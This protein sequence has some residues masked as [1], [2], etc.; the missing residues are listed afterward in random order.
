MNTLTRT[1]LLC[2]LVLAA[3]TG[4]VYA[5]NPLL[6]EFENAFVELSAFVRQSV[7]EISARGAEPTEE[8]RGRLDD[9]FRRL[10]PDR[11]RNEEHPRIMPRPASTGSGFIYDELGHIVTNNHVVT[12]AA[13]VTVELWD[14]TKRDA[15]VVGVD[16]S[17]DIAVIKIDPSGLE[18]KPVGLGSSENLKVGQFAIA[19]GSPRGQTGSL[20]FGHISGLAREHLQLPDRRLRF[21]SFIQTDAAINLGN[22]GGP[23]CNID[24]DVIGVNVAIAYGANSIGFAIPIDRVKE[25]VPQLIELGRVVRGWLGVGIRN[26]AEAARDAGQ[27]PDDYV[28]AYGLPDEKGA[29]VA[30]VT[31]DGP[32]ERAELQVDDVV[33]KID[34]QAV[35]D[36]TDLINI[37]SDLKPGTQVRLEIWREG[38]KKTIPVVVG[39]FPGDS[40]ARYGRAYLGMHVVEP[41]SEYAK[42][43]GFEADV[44][45]SE[46]AVVIVEPGTPAEKA[47]IKR[48]DFIVKVAQKPVTDRN[49]FR[50]LI[51][52]HAKPG[53]TLLI[54]VAR[55]G[56]EL[57]AKFIQVPED[58]NLD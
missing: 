17:A 10:I 28:E 7:V 37:V 27:E 18:L 42:R 56:K 15:V 41:D 38:E 43:M 6:K 40:Q 47:G 13:Q 24:G 34:N 33:R 49:S 36:T 44:L 55:Q 9:L 26:V 8:E 48:G 57:E 22:S 1:A 39:E 25:I 4:P 52:A 31:W 30:S 12:E 46:V 19:I 5:A 16:P 3:L 45:P 53:K 29:H 20:S 2:T 11:E 23:L 21:Q 58:F 51:R 50:E 32:A 14:G 54:Q 35:E